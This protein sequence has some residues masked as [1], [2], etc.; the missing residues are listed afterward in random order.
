MS[1]LAESPLEE[2]TVDPRAYH[3][4]NYQGQ[5][6]LFDRASGAL[7]EFEHHSPDVAEGE[8]PHL[9]EQAIHALNAVQ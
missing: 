1:M 5:N 4:F 7:F 2:Q 3:A 8:T 9:D 6:F